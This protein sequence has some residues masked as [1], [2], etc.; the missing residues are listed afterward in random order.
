[1]HTLLLTAHGEVWGVGAN[2]VGSMGGGRKI[3][4][5]VVRGT[6]RDL[7]TARRDVPSPVVKLHSTGDGAPEGMVHVTG[8]RAL[9]A[10]AYHCAA[11]T[12]DGGV[13]S[14]GKNV[15]GQ[16]GLGNNYARY[17]P[18]PNFVQGL[19]P[20][21]V[22]RSA[23]MCCATEH[24]VLFVPFGAKPLL[25][26]RAIPDFKDVLEEPKRRAEK[27]ITKTFEAAPAA[28]KEGGEEAVGA[29]EAAEAVE[30]GGGEGAEVIAE[31]MPMAPEPMAPKAE[32]KKP[33]SVIDRKLAGARAKAEA[34]AKGMNEA[35]TAA[36][37]AERTGVPA[38]APT[39]A[40]MGDEFG[41][42]E[43]HEGVFFSPAQSKSKS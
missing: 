34:A 5:G 6:P 35:Q 24:T 23:S 31:S 10:G 7:G 36:L 33:M 13:F 18:G 28:P 16:L 40:P 29:A 4:P 25:T 11:T 20:D 9:W 22:L 27:V 43:G 21:K 39:P 32:K 30:V 41:A 26:P 19:P 15:E 1:M 42:L 17:Q 38:P 3:V 8:I 2:V 12:A 14:W 37:I